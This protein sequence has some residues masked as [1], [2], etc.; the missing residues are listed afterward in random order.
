MIHLRVE[1]DPPRA[2]VRE[3]VLAAIGADS[4]F[5][6]AGPDTAHEAVAVLNLGNGGVQ[7]EWYD[8]DEGE[9]WPPLEGWRTTVD[10]STLEPWLEDALENIADYVEFELQPQRR[11][12]LAAMAEVSTRIEDLL[13]A[14]NAELEVEN[15][16][17]RAELAKVRM[18]AEHLE[19]ALR[20]LREA[21]AHGSKRNIRGQLAAVKGILEVGAAAATIGTLGIVVAEQFDSDRDGSV[22]NYFVQQC[23]EIEPFVDDLPDQLPPVVL[24]DPNL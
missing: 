7:V 22:T 20:Q 11:Q 17:L 15:S 4:R 5:V 21:T 1:G 12:L 2:G 8:G 3:S 18:R 14:L 19:L 13:W 10:F 9:K 23:V 24:E 6:L 16:R